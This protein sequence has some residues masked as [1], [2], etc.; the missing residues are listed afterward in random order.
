MAETFG[1]DSPQRNQ[2]LKGIDEDLVHLDKRLNVSNMNSFVN[3]IITSDHGITRRPGGDKQIEIGKKL[4]ELRLVRDV[5]MIVGSGA[6]TMIHPK[7]DPT[8][9]V[10]DAPTK[11]NDRHMRIVRG[12]KQVLRGQADVYRKNE[13]PEHLHWKVF[14]LNILYYFV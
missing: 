12:L 7:D 4:R 10:L 11:N 1:P 5:A 9:S 13:I 14:Y 6:Y 3:V 8:E 2:A